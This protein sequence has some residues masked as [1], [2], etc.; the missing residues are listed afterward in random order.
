MIHDKLTFHKN[1]FLYSQHS[2]LLQKKVINS[3]WNSYTKWNNFSWYYQLLYWHCN[4][5]FK[6]KSQ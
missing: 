3:K 6:T 4:A 2:S 5:Y 1:Q